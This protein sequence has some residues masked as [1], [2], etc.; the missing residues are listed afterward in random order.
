M[1]VMEVSTILQRS[2]FYEDTDLK[3]QLSRSSARVPA[4]IA[5]GFGQLTDKHV[6]T[7]LRKAHTCKF[8]S[9]EERRDLSDKYVVIGKRLSKWITYLR[10]S[11]WKQ[12][13]YG[14]DGDTSA[15][16]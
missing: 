6:A 11:N 15:T 10:R 4:L 14:A 13:Y 3:D 1:Q 9:N 12:R 2:C 16:A 8:I 5:E 7:H